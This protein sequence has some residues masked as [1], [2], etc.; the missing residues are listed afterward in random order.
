M[1]VSAFNSVWI[2]TYPYEQRDVPKQA[3]FW[4]HGGGCKPSCVGCQNG[5]K[6]KV[7]WTPK[8]ECAARLL[9]QCDES[10]LELLNPHTSSVNASKATDAD[11]EIPCNEGISYLP[12]QKAGIAY[13]IQRKNT[14]IA[15]E[16]GLGKTVQAL[17]VVNASVDSKNV[18]VIAPASLRINWKKESEKWLTGKFE[19]FVVESMKDKIPEIAS[20]VIVNYELVRGKKVIDPSG[21][22]DHKGVPVKIIASS[23][24]HSQLMNREW[25]VLIVDEAHRLTDPKSLQSIAILGFSASKKKGTAE[26][27]G[28]KSKAK[29]S[30]FL[31]GTPFMNRPIE[32]QPL[33]AAISPEE[34]G[35]FFLFAKRYAAA[36]QT[37]RGHWDFSGSSNL[38]E[39]QERLRATCMLRRLKRDVLQELPPKRRQIIILPSD[40]NAKVIKAEHDSWKLREERIAKLRNEVDFAHASNNE[41]IYKKSVQELKS[42]G[43]TGFT[44]MAKERKNV[45]IAKIPSVI[46]HLESAFEQDIEKII[47]FCWHNEV[48]DKIHAHFGSTAVK[49]TGQTTSNKDR[50]DAVDRF[51]I[52]PGIKLF[53]GSI[54]AAGVGHTLT[55]ASVVIFAELSWSPYQVTQ[56][57]DRAHRIGQQNQV[58]VQH[59]VFDGSIDA[60]MASTLIEK[61][62]IADRLL[63][64]DTEIDVAIPIT[65]TRR[66]GSYPESPEV[67]KKTALLAMQT[68]AQMD[69][70]D[71]VDKP[72]GLKLSQQEEMTDGQVWLA[73]SFSRKYKNKLSSEIIITLGIDPF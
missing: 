58:L 37:D 61:Q 53:V 46:D 42:A 26:I 20:L 65:T 8:P 68:L 67:K 28:L 62:S 14:L 51:Q 25:D 70:F 60:R 39:L 21:A 63:D 24:I 57:E 27:R 64:N 3:G 12:Y 13:A 47:L 32:L 52:D 38:E 34:F 33:L 31:T 40:K 44:E 48:S 59:L 66:P 10:A 7:W 23:N 36:H 2:A 56:A 55:A 73:T 11:I 30:L 1:G 19:V 49:L 29:K 54:G 45:A 41:E 35:N 6:L 72:V 22:L 5:L 71:E 9:S 69:G 4:W 16:M 43:L 18:L 15:D 17:G 50:Q